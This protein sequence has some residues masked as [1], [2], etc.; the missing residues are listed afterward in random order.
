MAVCWPLLDRKLA[1]FVATVVFPQPP[2]E[3]AIMIRTG[4][5]VWTTRERSPD[6]GVS[7][8]VELL[9]PVVLFIAIGSILIYTLVLD[10]FLIGFLGSSS[11]L[12][13]ALILMLLGGI[14]TATLY[15]EK[16]RKSTRLNSSHV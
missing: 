11:M 4:A 6:E 12:R 14:I 10:C 5:C 3:L 9:A 8:V 7:E 15:T 1:R 13:I 2:L 16:D